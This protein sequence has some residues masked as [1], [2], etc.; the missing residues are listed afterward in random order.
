MRIEQEIKQKSPF[1]NEQHRAHV[2]IIF[3]YH[4][5]MEQACRYV[6]AYDITMQQYNVLR[7]L[8]GANAPL[9]TR[10]I[11]DRM[12]DRMSDTSRIVERLQQ[13]G[14]VE[15]AVSPRDKR[16]VDVTIS[17]KGK[18]LLAQMDANLKDFDDVMTNLDEEDAARLNDLLDKLRG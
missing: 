11:R 8:R 3:T 17:E 4:W 13:K 6:K 16:L 15:R 18:A 1:R 12:L 10:T 7:I 9:S 2:N 5:I 14:L